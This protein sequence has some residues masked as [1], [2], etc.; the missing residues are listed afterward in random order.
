MDESRLKGFRLVEPPPT[1]G[2]RDFVSLVEACYA[3]D[4]PEEEWL[5]GVARAAFSVLQRGLG[6]GLLHTSG[7]FEDGTFEIK[8]W[9]IVGERSVADAFLSVFRH[10]PPADAAKVQAARGCISVSAAFGGRA[11]HLERADVQALRAEA[12]IVDQLIVPLLVSEHESFQ[13]LGNLATPMAFPPR[14]RGAM[15]R[16]SAHFAAAHRLR[17]ALAKGEQSSEAVLSEDGQLLHAEGGARERP[18]RSALEDAARAINSARGPLRNEAPHEALEIWKGLVDGRWSLVRQQDRDGKRVLMA[19]R[20]LPELEGPATLTPVERY[21][22]SLVQ[23]GHASKLI[24]YE[25]GLSPAAVSQN[26]RTA[27]RK[28]GIRHASELGR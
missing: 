23:K 10:V 24:A 2:K 12:G 5:T 19:R 14:L 26:L 3:F 22:V 25:L 17:A 18:A 15:Q 27:L 11:R 28:L 9:L 6:A 4:A 1:S 21:V 8:H 13:L 20:N 7:K 16:V